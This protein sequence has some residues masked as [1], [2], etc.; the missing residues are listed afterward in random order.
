MSSLLNSIF[1][2]IGEFFKSPVKRCFLFVGILLLAAILEYFYLG[3]A[4]RT[5]VFYTMSDGVVVVEDRMLKHSQSRE[6][7]IIRYVEEALLGP[8]SPNLLPLFP[9]GTRLNSLMYRD[10]IVYADFTSNAAMPPIEGGNTLQNF[11]TLYAGILRNFSFIN[12]VRF[13]IEG[14]VIFIEEIQYGSENFQEVF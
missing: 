10:G 2:P 12:D 5:F 3:L 9:G 11:R 1:R 14:N 7:D 13:F 8:V 4:R 6:G